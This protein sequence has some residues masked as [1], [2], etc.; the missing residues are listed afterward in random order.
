MPIKRK[1]Q[2]LGRPS[3]AYDS[4]RDLVAD[5]LLWLTYDG[6]GFHVL[7]A[8]WDTLIIFDACR[9]DVFNDVVDLSGTF[10]QK[11][12]LGS[13]TYHFAKRNFGGRVAHDVVYL[14]DNSVVGTVHND[15]Y[16]DVFKFVGTWNEEERHAKQG[17]ENVKA[18]AEPEP[19]VDKAIELHE[20]Y[21]NKRHIVHL[22]P[23]HT[24]HLVEDGE[25]LPP[26]SPCRN[27][28]AVRE[29]EISAERIRVV[30]RDNVQYVADAV[31]P[32]IKRIDGKVV[33]TSDHGELLGESFPK[34]KKLCNGRF[35][36]EWAKYNWGHYGDI[37]IPEL[38]EVPWLEL[39]CESRRRIV[40]DQ[41]EEDE[42]DTEEIEDHLEALGYR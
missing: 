6:D 3:N 32:L 21:P 16:I 22:L 27:Y 24:P 10:T 11:R 29:G 7:E 1:L 19:V 28:E 41:P 12:S 31:K 20:E 35:G 34:W 14:S 8:E 23:P 4:A 36:T 5:G 33:I 2:S 42:F 15:G 17:H 37:D 25:P 30:Y 9:N 26:D 13:I 38:V 40:S 39:P 18:V